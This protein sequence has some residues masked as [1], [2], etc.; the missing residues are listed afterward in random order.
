MEP[1]AQRV[2]IPLAEPRGGRPVTPEG[3][4]TLLLIT[5]AIL[6]LFA[7]NAARPRVDTPAAPTNNSVMARPEVARRIKSYSAATGTVYQYYFFEVQKSR[8][9][10]ASGTEFTYMIST[11][12][13]TVFPLR[14]F[15]RRDALEKWAQDNGRSLSGTEEY[16][17]AKMRL[18]RAFDE[19]EDLA[20]A[21]PDLVVD[22][23]NLES[24]LN[25]L[26]I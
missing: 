12:R 2:R 10:P 23:S 21:R 26:G 14:I 7:L 13:K 11:D 16:A 18:F 20:T 5:R 4:I 3:V 17:V 1:V 8:R 25:D 22:F 6:S 15:V 24:L 19:V 9:G